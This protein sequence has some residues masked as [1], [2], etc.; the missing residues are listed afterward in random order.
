MGSIQALLKVSAAQPLPRL[1]RIL[2]MARRYRL[3]ASQ[4][5][6]WCQQLQR[7][8]VAA[9]TNGRP[10]FMPVLLAAAI[11]RTCKP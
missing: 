9:E 5:F 4:L 10:G 6:V 11:T 3:H 2:G 8:A 1:C 7:N